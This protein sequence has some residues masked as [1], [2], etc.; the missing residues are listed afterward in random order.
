MP[1]QWKLNQQQCTGCGICADL[2][3][4]GAIHMSRE[5]AYPEAVSLRCVGCQVCVE[6]CPVD[7]IEINERLPA[8]T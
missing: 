8:A 3:P 2:C 5:V 4:H 6:Q 7:A 1:W